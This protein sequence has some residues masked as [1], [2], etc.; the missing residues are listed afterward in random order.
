MSRSEV[1]RALTDLLPALTVNG[2]RLLL[3]GR[4]TLAAVLSAQEDNDST[5]ETDAMHVL[6]ACLLLLKHFASAFPTSLGAAETLKETCRGE[7]CALFGSFGI[8]KLT[9]FRAR[10]LQRSPL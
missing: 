10:S 6:E 3:A 5:C 7:L 4:L 8:G 2:Y 1:L 9:A